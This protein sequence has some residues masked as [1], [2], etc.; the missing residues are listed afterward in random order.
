MIRSVT[1]NQYL[2]SDP[3]D[4][5]DRLAA[6]LFGRLGNATHSGC[7]SQYL[8][9]AKGCITALYKLDMEDAV[10]CVRRVVYLLEED[11]FLCPP[12][13]YEV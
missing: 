13:K 5:I 2:I 3:P 10:G 12:D 1:L 11:T 9:T 4:E 6:R 8:H 7:R